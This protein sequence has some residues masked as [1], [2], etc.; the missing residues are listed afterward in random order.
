MIA[1][2]CKHDQTKRFGHDRKGNQRYRCILCGKTWIEETP[3][4]L[5]AMR[6][7]KTKAVLCLR[8]LLE[9]NS[10]RSTERITGVHRD[11]ILVLL[12]TLGRRAVRYWETKMIDLP[13]MDVEC[14]EI[15]GFIGCKEKT[16]QREHYS[17]EYGDAYCFT[18]IERTSKL[19]L[20]WWLGRRT[21]IDTANFAERLRAAVP[22]RCQLTADGFRPYE[23]VIPAVFAGQVDFAQLVKVYTNTP[24]G[25]NTRY[26]PG[27][28]MDVRMHNV[29]GYP[30]PALVSTSF[31]ER[32]NL[33]IRMAVRRMTRL[34]NAFSK[35]RVNHEYHLALYFLYYNFCR[36]HLTLGTTPAVKA[37]VAEKKW[38]VEKLLD[39]LA[40]QS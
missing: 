30:D 39:E 12:E 14:D 36:V 40:T 17:E 18:A 21:G 13:A 27:A 10:I 31:V 6:L 22:R 2:A 29:C 35:K 1:P 38:T 37:G 7:D 8:L 16:R 34:T 4:T 33:N 24:D 23:S 11:T 25:P 20:A 5:G 3:K 28:I 15:W 19:M 9:G 26:S 32:Q